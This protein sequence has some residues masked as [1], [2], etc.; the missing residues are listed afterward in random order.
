M[1]H[2]MISAAKPFDMSQMIGDSDFDQSSSSSMQGA[3]TGAPSFADTLST[4]FNNVNKLQNSA[5]D[6]ATSFALGQVN[7]IHSVMIA[8]QKATV[9][10]DLT[11]EIRNNVVNAYQDV[12]RISM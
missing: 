8:Q 5:T 6:A 11:T 12:M 10:L 3:A 2:S 4:A 7:D 1:S 9:A